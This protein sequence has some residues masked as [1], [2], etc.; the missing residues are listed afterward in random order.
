MP[1]TPPGG[2]KPISPRVYWISGAAAVALL[3]AIILGV[4]AFSQLGKPATPTGGSI[5]LSPPQQGDQLAQQ[6]ESALAS[7]DTTGAQLLASKALAVDAQNAKAKK[8][9]EEINAQKQASQT[10]QETLPTSTPPPPVS[11]DAGF[12]TAVSDIATLL[13]KTFTGYS[14]GEP[15]KDKTDV[16]MS[17]IP[18]SASAQA[19]RIIWA[20]HEFKNAAA[21][22]TYVQKVSKATFS[23]D[24]ASVT[25]DGVSGY[26]GTD[27]TRFATVAYVR[28]RYVFEV[29]ATSS[30]VAPKTLRTIAL[31]A[32]AAFPD[33][34][35]K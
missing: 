30:G 26:F 29:L 13:P 11:P 35:P 20:V 28:G 23:H 14:L 31:K 10:H 6:G 24:G 27:G 9:L 8:L 17:G 34:P 3:A 18:D 1:S 21:A 2:R 22:K 5:Q 15:A 25:V 4:G 19:E 32:S 12:L 7:G 33:A 16:N